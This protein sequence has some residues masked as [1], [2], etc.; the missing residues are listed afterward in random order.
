MAV[1]GF[2]SVVTVVTSPRQRCR[3][4]DRDAAHRLVRSRRYLS[5]IFPARIPLQTREVLTCSYC[6]TATV[7]RGG[8]TTA[9]A[10]HS[11]GGAVKIPDAALAGPAAVEGAGGRC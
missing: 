5:L 8:A 10:S 3:S 2:R 4:C 7:V 1:W 9:T 6:G 11:P